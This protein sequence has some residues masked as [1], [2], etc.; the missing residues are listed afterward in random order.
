M[1]PRIVAI[2][3]IGLV[4]LLAACSRPQVESVTV[5][6]V[7]A[8]ME[9][10]ETLALTARVHPP[11][12]N[13]SVTWSSDAPAIASV[14]S[15]GVVTG[16]SVGATTITATSVAN[17]P[18]VATATVTVVESTAG[19][20]ISPE[21]RVLTGRSQEVLASFDP[22]T[23]NLVFSETT[24]FLSELEPGAILVSGIADAAPY[25]LL[26]TVEA[27]DIA[28]GEVIVT[29]S[30]ASLEDVIVEGSVT[31]TQQ[32]GPEDVA[33]IE[34]L[35]HGVSVASHGAPGVA[36]T[37]FLEYTWAFDFDHVLL[38]VDEPEYRLKAT[39]D[40]GIGLSLTPTFH[41]AWRGARLREF[42]VTVGLSQ[43]AELN[44]QVDGGGSFERELPFARKTLSPVTVMIGPVPIV[45]TYDILLYIGARGELDVEVLV[46]LAQTLDSQLGLG[47][48]RD[49]TPPWQPIATVDLGFEGP[50]VAFS[51]NAMA[52]GYAAA[53]FNMMLYGVIGPGIGVR[54]FGEIEVELPG[55]PAWCVTAGIEAFGSFVMDVPVL[56]RIVDH[57]SD[58]AEHRMQ[59]GCSE[60]APPQI[61]VRAEPE[62]SVLLGSTTRLHAEVSDLEDGDDCCAVTWRSDVDGP[63]GTSS[64]GTP[65]LDVIFGSEGERT[66]TATA[67]D[68]DD[69]TAS[70]SLTYTVEHR[71]PRI[72]S[73]ETPTIVRAE[74]GSLLSAHG[75]DDHGLGG[76]LPCERISW[77]LEGA[78]PATAV[79]CEVWATFAAATASGAPG[80]EVV[81][82]A[83]GEHGKTVTSVHSVTVL[84]PPDN[85]VTAECDI[86]HWRDGAWAPV[87]CGSPDAA[88]G[89]LWQGES[90]AVR[91]VFELWATAS[92]R[93]GRELS[94]DWHVLYTDIDNGTRIQV[95][96]PSEN[97]TLS[98]IQAPAGRQ[99]IGSGQ[100]I[101]YD[102]SAHWNVRC[103][104]RKVTFILT[105]SDGVNEFEFP[106]SFEYRRVYFHGID[107]S[108]CATY[109]WW[110][111]AP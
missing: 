43:R 48:E 23:G 78:T 45:Y 80:H 42:E 50:D 100:A 27:V 14:S 25:G 44:L 98:P 20:E 1:R 7:D 36:T 53:S 11:S 55:H 30:E 85:E 77:A 75:E 37:S 99:R 3:I 39:V 79:G 73:F 18:V 94:Y 72:V 26:R 68:N 61:S 8:T 107:V 110:Q 71:P 5:E 40:G 24:E 56:G 29:T 38:D 70:A 46:S 64:S 88:T 57:Q 58:I 4:T 54:A 41:A 49:R 101:T 109:P 21:T 91:P 60:N 76:S 92:D 34:M 65:Y 33:D 93:L 16:E 19:V 17:P 67:T 81:L 87:T 89:T 66:I 82:T 13:Q 63:L 111:P 90:D 62:G 52:R 105:V 28:A 10:G 6:P 74:Q 103:E 97:F 104:I 9:V 96:D 51:A 22:A 59:L 83:R 86:E 47:Y 102:M 84:A 106:W 69:A 12:T 2:T 32:L 31:V 108:T 95:T 15:E 35:L